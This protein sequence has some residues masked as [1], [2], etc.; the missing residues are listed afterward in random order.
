M[1]AY[2]TV[3]AA[4]RLRPHFHGQGAQ[5]G[6]ILLGAGDGVDVLGGFAAGQ[7]LSGQGQTAVRGEGLTVD[8]QCRHRLGQSIAGERFPG[9]IPQLG[10][11]GIVNVLFVNLFQVTLRVVAHGYCGGHVTLAADRNH[12]QRHQAVAA[13]PQVQIVGRKADF[14]GGGF[15]HGD[16][17]GVADADIGGVGSRNHQQGT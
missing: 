13:L 3:R 14:R 8:P 7:G 1:A 11:E 16:A 9:G 5:Q 17:F 15:R 12:F 6:E 10:I 2:G 4:V